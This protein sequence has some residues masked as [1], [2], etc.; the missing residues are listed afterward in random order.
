MKIGAR[1]ARLSLNVGP[2]LSTYWKIKRHLRLSIQKALA[3]SVI[4]QIF[5]CGWTWSIAP[6]S[7]R[8]QR[9]PR[10]LMWSVPQPEGPTNHVSRTAPIWTICS[11]FVCE[12]DQLSPI[13]SVEPEWCCWRSLATGHL[14]RGSKRVRAGAG[15]RIHEKGE[16]FLEP[17]FGCQQVTL[18]SPVLCDTLLTTFPMLCS[19]RIIMLRWQT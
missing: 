16:T 19:R 13:I 12:H 15:T 17:G 10:S 14:D 7:V 2:F 8:D 18:I 5:I 9:H 11:C 4:T 1:V 3:V 6:L